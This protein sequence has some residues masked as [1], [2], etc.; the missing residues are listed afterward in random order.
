MK[1]WEEFRERLVYKRPPERFLLPGI[2]ARSSNKTD[3]PA[4]AQRNAQAVP[5]IPAPI[6]I[7]SQS[8]SMS[9]PRYPEH[10]TLT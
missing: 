1:L 4:R 9:C 8:S 2:S 10:N 7:M 3:K 6:I 5:A